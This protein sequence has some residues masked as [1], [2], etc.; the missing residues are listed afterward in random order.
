MIQGKGIFLLSFFY[1]AS[2]FSFF[3]FFLFIQ[4]II[5]TLT[6]FCPKSWT[7]GP[8]VLPLCGGCGCLFLR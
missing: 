7:S 3:S 2:A 8:L 6:P 4:R 1:A 5:F